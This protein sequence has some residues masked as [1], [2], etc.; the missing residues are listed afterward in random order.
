MKRR[1]FVSKVAIG[2]SILFVSP[3]YLSS[4]SKS[5]DTI[6]DT[7]DTG[8]TDPVT[9]DLTK[10]EFADLNTV[11]GYVYYDK[12]IIIRS[13][14]SEYHVLSKVC[15]HEGAWVEYV[16]STN[17]IMCSEHGAM[18]TIAGVVTKGPATRSLAAYTVSLSGNTLT[19]G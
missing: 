13:G 2:G 1:E 16:P 4:C 9:I 12:Y 15:T 17:R 11:G 14:E 8:T 6:T 7:P 19:I 18:F 10:S 5:G 3:Y